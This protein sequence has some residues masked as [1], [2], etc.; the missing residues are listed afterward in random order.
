MAGPR[1]ATLVLGHTLSNRKELADAGIGIATEMRVVRWTETE[2]PITVDDE[3]GETVVTV[4]CKTCGQPVEAHVLGIGAFRRRRRAWLSTGLAII[5]AQVTALALTLWA[6]LD[7]SVGW[8]GGVAFLVVLLTCPF[9]FVVASVDAG[10]MTDIARR[11]RPK[12]G[13]HSFRIDPRKP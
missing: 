11:H 7:G 12:D 5:A 9:G 13:V 10:Q 4:E 3:R 6:S 2:V 1:P 8:P